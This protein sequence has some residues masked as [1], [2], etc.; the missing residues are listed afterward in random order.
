MAD[1]KS[2]LLLQQSPRLN[3]L[4]AEIRY[5]LRLVPWQLSV[6]AALLMVNLLVLLFVILPQRSALNSLEQDA[7]DMRRKSSRN[8]AQQVDHSPQAT[9]NSFYQFLPLEAAAPILAGQLL[10][11][12]SANS[13][14]PEN[15][16]YQ[17]TRNPSA[18]FSR[19]QITLPVHADYVAVR[20]FSIDVLNALPN[21]ALSEMNFRRDEENQGQV[22]ARLR[23]SLYLGSAE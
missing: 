15:V 18:N 22:Q 17:L 5:R 8:H 11:A 23:F 10:K 9:L 7:S 3:N 19:Y 4:Y 20:Q 2:S 6:G 1:L 21:A 12:A 13:I 14:A 16:E